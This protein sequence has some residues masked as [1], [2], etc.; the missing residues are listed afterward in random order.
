MNHLFDLAALGVLCLF[1]S[2]GVYRLALRHPDWRLIYAA[3]AGS[4]VGV[5]L[6]G[7][8]FFV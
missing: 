7:A 8:G 4:I 6:A 1:W 5:I 2:G 3:N